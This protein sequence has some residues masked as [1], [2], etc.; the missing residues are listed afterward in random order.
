MKQKD[1]VINS[2]NNNLKQ[3]EV[4]H[5]IIQNYKVLYLFEGLN[6]DIGS[7]FEKKKILLSCA[8]FSQAFILRFKTH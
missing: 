4:P 5:S 6:N 1:V 7:R 2:V 3:Y 8:G